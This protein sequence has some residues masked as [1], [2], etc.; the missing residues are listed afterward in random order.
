MTKHPAPYSPTIL[1]AMQQW[2]DKL[3]TPGHMWRQRPFILD[4]MAGSGRIHQLTGFCTVGVELEPEWAEMH[5]QTRVG[6]ATALVFPDRYFD[7]CAVSP[8]YGNR[9]A[10][11]H[12][13]QDGSYRRTY[14]HTLGRQLSDNNAGA[15]Q[16]GDEYRALHEK[17]WA[18]VYRVLKPGAPFLLN[19]K[20]HIR[21]GRRQ[22]VTSWHYKII[23]SLGFRLLS[24]QSIDTPHF[25]YGENRERCIEKLLIFSKES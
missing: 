22:H 20:D 3:A 2:L 18:E 6:D 19:C 17:A 15:M 16:W 13:A 8:C 5:P 7:G 1:A 11:H 23:K 12:N 9:M 21:G 4:P 14:R 25:Q 24:V 10:D